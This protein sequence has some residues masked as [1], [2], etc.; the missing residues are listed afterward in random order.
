MRSY[1]SG[2][3]AWRGTPR[4][5]GVADPDLYRLA[6]H[7]AM[8]PPAGLNRGGYASHTM[9]RLTDVGRR[10]L[11]PGERRAVY[12]R[13]Q[14]WAAHDLPALPLWWEERVVVS[15]DRLRG[16]TPQPSGDLGGLAT[17]VL[18]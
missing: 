14:R 1:E 11:D 17:A 13:V 16:F 12:A 3:G 15:T 8:R 9:D 18:Q 4:F 2:P 6:Y 5:G 7:S 10:T